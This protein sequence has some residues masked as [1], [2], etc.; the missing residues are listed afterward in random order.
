MSDREELEAALEGL[1]RELNPSREPALSTAFELLEAQWKASDPTTVARGL[2]YLGLVTKAA[3]LLTQA[4][5]RGVADQIL[6]Q[7]ERQVLTGNVRLATLTEAEV[8]RN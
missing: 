5:E 3:G 6:R 4:G 7:L 1:R 8:R 2:L